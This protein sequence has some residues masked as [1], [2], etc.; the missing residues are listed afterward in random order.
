ME[1]LLI[2]GS[3]GH[4]RVVAETAEASGKYK[5]IGFADDDDRKQGKI[6]DGIPVLGLWRKVENVS[7]I[8][9]IGDNQV[10]HRLYF[11]L[12]QSGRKVG[13]VVSSRSFVSR[14]AVI[15]DG[16]VILTGAVVQP[17]ARIGKNVIIN[18]GSILDHDCVIGDSAHV[19]PNFTVLSCSEVK[20]LDF[21]GSHNLRGEGS[22]R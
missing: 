15:G 2:I 12:I 5:V 13:T 3:G 16:T 14:T 8:V 20:P 4:G 11:E 6:V 1:P 7:F 22:V 10:R 21:L 9:A 18:A 17:G 19:G